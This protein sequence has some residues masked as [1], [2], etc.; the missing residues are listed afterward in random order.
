MIA[1]HGHPIP[2]QWHVRSALGNAIFN[3]ARTII[4]VL[5]GAGL[6][7]R[8]IATCVN[9]VWDRTTVFVLLRSSVVALEYAWVSVIFPSTAT[10]FSSEVYD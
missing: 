9:P 4:D 7:L 8:L 6:S 2:N 5:Q 1:P 10:I 3:Q